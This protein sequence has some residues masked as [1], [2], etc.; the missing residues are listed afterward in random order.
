MAGAQSHQPLAG[1]YL[2]FGKLS[3]FGV[4][5]P[6]LPAENSRICSAN[7][8][9]CPASSHSCAHGDWGKG[10]EVHEP[11]MVSSGINSQGQGADPHGGNLIEE[12]LLA[13]LEKKKREHTCQEQTAQGHLGRECRSLAWSSPCCQALAGRHGPSPS[14]RALPVPVS[15]VLWWHTVCTTKTQVPL[16][17]GE[18]L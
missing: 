5:L 14:W 7:L 8:S 1:V 18:T 9:N 2:L 16:S 11:E 13:I 4:L 6:W 3:Q 17:H 10:Q 12:K 15:P